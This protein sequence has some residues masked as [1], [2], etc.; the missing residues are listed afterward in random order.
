MTSI[1]VAETRNLDIHVIIT[2][3]GISAL[4]TDEPHVLQT[5][6]SGGWIVE[7]TIPLSTESAVGVFIYRPSNFIAQYE[8][9]I[10]P[11]VFV[12]I[13]TLCLFSDQIITWDSFHWDDIQEESGVNRGWFD[14]CSWETLWLENYEVQ[15]DDGFR[16]AVD[17]PSTERPF[18]SNNLM[19]RHVSQLTKGINVVDMQF[20]AFSRHL[21]RGGEIDRMG[22]Q[23][24]LPV[25]A[26]SGII[27]DQCHYFR[28]SGSSTSVLFI[29][30]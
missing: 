9:V 14:Y 26:S 30:R 2:V 24:P 4:P 8:H 6:L 7:L 3:T 16:L 18:L 17:I 19:L 29:N 10:L 21:R 1:A 23:S 28:T 5:I 12:E 25:Y 13:R 20:L 27:Q 11:P 22:A 15:R